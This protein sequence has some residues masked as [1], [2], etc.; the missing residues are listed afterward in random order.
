M[1]AGKLYASDKKPIISFEFFPPRNEQ[2]AQ[3]FD[4]VVGSLATLGPDYMSVTF[5]AGGSTRE[6]SY[7]TVKQLLV[8]KKIPTV[9]YLAGFGLAPDE[10]TQVLDRYRELGV[11][12]IFVIRGD[13]PQDPDFKPHP[14]SFSHASEMIAFIKK[15]Y[16]FCLGCAG[17]PEGHIQAESREKDIAFLKLKQDNGAQ[18]VITQYCYDNDVFFRYVEKCRAAGVTIPIIP[19]I[20]PVYTI[21][22][23]QML[24]KICG[25]TITTDLQRGLDQVDPG[26][27]D[28]VLDFGVDF[29]VA[30]CRGLIDKGVSALHFYTMDRSRSTTAIINRLREE[31]L[32]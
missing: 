4:E 31:K 26:D 22:M 9:A 5:G 1:H 32:L 17:Y 8:E 23:T 13:Q 12:T 30:Q 3:T 18:Y 7:Q 11:E 20:M 16:D 28:A 19:G 15:R 6:G 10:I 21:K 2:A 27:K 14:E 24:S 25:T 29:A